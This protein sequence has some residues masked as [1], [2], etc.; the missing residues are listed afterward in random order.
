MKKYASRFL[1]FVALLHMATP[2]GYLIWVRFLFEIPPQ[3][4]AS[5]LLSPFYYLVAIA[6]AVSGYGLWEM[7]RWSWH[8]FLATSFLICYSNAIILTN[9]GSTQHS[10]EMFAVSCFLVLFFTLRVAR[11]LRVP[12]FLPKIRWW[13]S[14]PR[15]RTHIP[16]ELAL[17][18]SLSDH[19]YKAEIVDLSTKGAF[20]KIRDDFKVGDV[21]EL[22]FTAFGLKA[23]I[24]GTVVWCPQSAVTHPKGVGIKFG[25][26]T[27]VNRKAL[28]A[29]D[30]RLKRIRAFY[31]TYRL[32][33]AEE[34]FSKRMND[35][36]APAT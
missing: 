23:E 9:Y 1:K 17:A 27:R 32:L 7:R 11:E 8:V 31:R 2:V 34:E 10:W 22:K 19:F 30:R 35:L 14:N 12:Y 28:R 26:M 29:M 5:L 6:A 24:A 16:V 20:V 21:L 3:K 18:D 13:E 25:T 36:H 15:Y 4:M 33:M